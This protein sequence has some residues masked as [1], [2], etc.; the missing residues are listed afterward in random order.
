MH[1]VTK[2]EGEI[3]ISHAR[4]GHFFIVNSVAAVLLAAVLTFRPT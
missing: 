2:G 3:K 4:E 1:C